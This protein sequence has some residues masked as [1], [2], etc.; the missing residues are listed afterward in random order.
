MTAFFFRFTVAVAL[1]ALELF[2]GNWGV[3]L[4]LTAVAVIYFSWL[5]DSRLAIVLLALISG[6]A[7]DMAS[8][9]SFPFSTVLL[10]LSCL[11][12]RRLLS[13]DISKNALLSATICGGGFAIIESIYWV[14]LEIA[15]F[16]IFQSIGDIVLSSLLSIFFWALGFPIF[17]MLLD[18]VAERIGLPT[19]FEKEENSSA[20]TPRRHLRR[21][22]RKTLKNRNGAGK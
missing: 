4:P 2:L 7:L 19:F 1:V 18:L 14:M 10:L 11:A 8:G 16:N 17:A 22:N 12:S 15:G 5:T 21:I 20:P 9:R 13:D 3:A 6:L